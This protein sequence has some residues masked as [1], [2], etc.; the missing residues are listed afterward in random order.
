MTGSWI[1]RV[2]AVEHLI[3]ASAGDGDAFARDRALWSWT[4]APS[5]D[6]WLGVPLLDHP[7]RQGVMDIDAVVADVT[8]D[9]NDD[10]LAF[11]LTGGSGACGVWSVI[12]LGS[13]NVV[14]RRELCD[15]WID[16]STQPAGLLVTESVYRAGDPHCCPSARRETVVFYEDDGW[17]VFR[18]R[19]TAS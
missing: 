7:A 19:T 10:V 17:Q 18:R 14:Y 6:G 4:P 8:G 11:S 16:P 3:V 1:G 15:G 13:R 2:G 5:F 12:D 9:S